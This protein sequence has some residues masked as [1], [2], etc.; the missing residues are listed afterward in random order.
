MDSNHINIR[1]N[2]DGRAE[3]FYDIDLHLYDRNSVMLPSTICVVSGG[4][5]EKLRHLS[6]AEV[7]QLLKKIKKLRPI[8]DG[9]CVDRCSTPNDHY[10]LLIKSAAFRLEHK[11]N[12]DGI[13]NYKKLFKSLMEVVNTIE[14]MHPIDHQEFGLP[15]KM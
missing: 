11:W 13:E 8:Y 9:K 5:R 2:I 6:A 4:T 7:M 14:Q 10:R 1:Y 15:T 3:I 12:S